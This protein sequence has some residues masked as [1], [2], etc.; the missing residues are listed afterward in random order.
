MRWGVVMYDRRMVM[1]AQVMDVMK[2]WTCSLFDVLFN[3][4]SVVLLVEEREG[5]LDLSLAFLHYV[6]VG[7]RFYASMLDTPKDAHW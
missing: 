2:A 1:I 3:D 4:T 6:T 5:R 7:G